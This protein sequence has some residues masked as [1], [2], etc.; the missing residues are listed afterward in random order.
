MEKNTLACESLIDQ[1]S[2]DILFLTLG[3]WTVEP[4]RPG[5]LHAGSIVTPFQLRHLGQVTYPLDLPIL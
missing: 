4:S 5:F 3:W 1:V 2:T